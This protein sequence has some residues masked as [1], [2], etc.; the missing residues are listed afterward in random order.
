MGGE[1]LVK[2]P[3]GFGVAYSAAEIGVNMIGMCS[4]K[5]GLLLKRRALKVA[6]QKRQL[7]APFPTKS[8]NTP[9][10]SWRDD[11]GNLTRLSPH[12]RVWPRKK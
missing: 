7:R 3:S 4:E 11:D 6:C 9:R 12:M 2:F 1:S 5:E 10:N 8:I